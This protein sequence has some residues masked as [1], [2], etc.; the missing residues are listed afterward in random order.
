MKEY[1][2]ILVF[3]EDTY[4]V[5]EHGV[6]NPR[7]HIIC[8][9]GF[10]MSVQAS[11]FHHCSPRLNLPDGGY[12][13]C[14]IGF[15]SREDDLLLPYADDRKKPTRTIYPMVPIDV[16]DNVIRKHGGSFQTH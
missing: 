16:I 11:K 9:D 10:E 5:D 1:K 4:S 3:L 13:A 7:P 6:M 15:P 2:A 12:F 14:E 8:K